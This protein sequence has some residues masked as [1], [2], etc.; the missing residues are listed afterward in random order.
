MAEEHE[1]V[2]DEEEEKMMQRVGDDLRSL[3]DERD[4]PLSIQARL[5]KARFFTMGKF[6]NLEDSRAAVR[7]AAVAPLPDGLGLAAGGIAGKA[8]VSSLIDA[9][10]SAVQFVAV[11][12][13]V[14]AEARATRTTAPLVKNDHLRMRKA[15]AQTHLPLEDKHV[16]ASGY[17]EKK[18][19]DIT[20]GSYRAETLKEVTSWGDDIGLSFD[21]IGTD[22]RSGTLTLKKG[23]KT[24]EL[25]SS[26][27]Q[28]RDKVKIMMVAF[29]YAKARFPN[30]R[31]LRTVTPS[32]F[33]QHVTFVL[34]EQVMG[35][36]SK[37]E[38]GEVIS[39]P[40]W[41]LVISFEFQL[42]K[43]ALEMISMEKEEDFASAMQAA[44]EDSVLFQRFFTTPLQLRPSTR[45]APRSSSNRQN[46]D[47]SRSRQRQGAKS[48]GKGG[49]KN[50]RSQGSG[51][52][53]GKGG[54]GG[55]SGKSAPKAY[56]GYSEPK[57]KPRTAD[58]RNICYAFNN[59]NEQCAEK[60]CSRAHC[61][62]WCE[63]NH[64]GHSCPSKGTIK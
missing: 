2:M 24:G 62:W 33:E 55:K 48:G 35:L 3:W 25:P 61:C 51:K 53:Y 6:A 29:I 13:E 5:A 15:F 57:G 17:V 64:A 32:V 41:A 43:R 60:T 58:G 59:P 50:K 26:P 1:Y 39:S 19:E 20:E 52:G 14:E 36:D 34:S 28:L 44:R 37:N 7:A 42:R 38:R 47:R 8:M 22:P 46:R 54:K 23:V 40:P 16:P 49:K 9:W 45:S 31:W 27:E 18:F 63:E 56:G 12:R 21:R 10:E 30:R 4:V 11:R